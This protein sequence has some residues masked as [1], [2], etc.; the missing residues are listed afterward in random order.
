[1]KMDENPGKTKLSVKQNEKHCTKIR[2]FD[3]KEI[4]LKRS[5]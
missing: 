2:K 4:K 5:P 3:E 1:M